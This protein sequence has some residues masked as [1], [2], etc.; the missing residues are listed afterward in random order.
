MR[1]A[2]LTS[3]PAKSTGN[4]LC[5]TR[6]FCNA[7]GEAQ[8][9]ERCLSP[10]AGIMR[11]CPDYCDYIP[12]VFYWQEKT[13]PRRIGPRCKNKSLSGN[14][15]DRDLKEKRSLLCSWFPCRRFK[16][17]LKTK[18]MTDISQT[19]AG[20]KAKSRRN[21]LWIPGLFNAKSCCVC[22]NRLYFRLFRYTSCAADVPH[23]RL[24]SR[25]GFLFTL[26][27]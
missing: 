5:I 22:R 26:L 17:Y 13:F 14:H 24:H 21:P 20:F 2:G 27:W 6:H 23:T 7:D 12:N 9:P 19:Q 3:C 1:R 15:P 8:P 16:V 10:W 4:I 25:P 11:G 18:K